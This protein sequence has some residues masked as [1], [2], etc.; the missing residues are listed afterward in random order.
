VFDEEIHNISATKIR[1]QMREDG[2]L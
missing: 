1:N 2:K